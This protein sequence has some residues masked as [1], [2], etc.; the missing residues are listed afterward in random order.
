[1]PSNLRSVLTLSISSLALLAAGCAVEGAPDTTVGHAEQPIIG[2]VPDTFRAYTVGVG[3]NQ[4]AFCTGVLISKRVVLTAGH[5]F[6]GISRIF[7]GPDLT[8]NPMVVTVSQEIR[9]PQ[10]SDVTLSNDL[11]ILQ[12]AA[13]APV[14]S[15]PLLR[16]TMDNTP[17]YIGPNFNYVGYG[18]D[19]FGNYDVR[20]VVAF[21]IVAVGPADVGQDTGSGPIDAT[22]F[23]YRTT[24]KNT[25]DGDSGGPSFFVKGMVERVAGT[26]SYGDFDCQI[27][28]VNARTDGPAIQAFIQPHIDAFENMDG[29]RADGACNDACNVGK[30]VDPDCADQHCG[31]DGI[32]A[33]SCVNP[34]DPDCAINHCGADGSCDPSCNPPDPDCSAT[35]SSSSS[36]STSSSSTSSSGGTGGSGGAG[37]AGAG[38][39]G[40]GGSGGQFAPKDEGGC[41]CRTSEGEGKGALWAFALLALA[42]IR[43]RRV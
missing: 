12:L 5:C 9:H 14:Q 16:D 43:R 24:G 36:S 11:T 4:G 30:L 35:S 29:C 17:T 15:V 26:T 28:G 41:G 18:A 7:I 20:R 13:D 42:A 39:G 1:M 22:Q 2:G 8:Q 31:Q 3:D 34:P 19:D 21:P 6:G 32:C 27:D 23:Y 25:C 37:G 40:D 33:L 38:G 10:Y